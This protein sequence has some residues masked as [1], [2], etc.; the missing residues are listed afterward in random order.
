MHERVI[1]MQKLLRR[2]YNAKFQGSF[3]RFNIAAVSKIYTGYIHV[4]T[5][6]HKHIHSYITLTLQTPSSSRTVLSID[7]TQA[8][9][10]IPSTAIWQTWLAV[11]NS[12]VSTTG[13]SSMST[14]ST[15]TR[16]KRVAADSGFP[17]EL[18]QTLQA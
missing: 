7:S 10:A 18:C 16:P 8:L 14:P 12:S 15:Y 9:C 11:A 1:F 4:C 13:G 3:I 5:K 17:A 2:A 6:N